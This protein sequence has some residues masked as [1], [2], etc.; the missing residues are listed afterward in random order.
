MN[1]EVIREIRNA[2]KIQPGSMEQSPNPIPVV[3]VG[4]KSV[5]NAF[6]RSNFATNSTG[7]TIFTTSANADTYLVSAALTMIKDATATATSSSITIVYNGSTELLISIPEITLTAQTL[8]VNI[9]LPHPIKL[10]RGSLVRITNSTNVGNISSFGSV[11]C[12]L[13]EV[14]G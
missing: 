8:S 13:D 7:V 1:D 10:D 3:E 14:N 9:T 2:F 4:L 12:Y 6:V 11:I 5:K